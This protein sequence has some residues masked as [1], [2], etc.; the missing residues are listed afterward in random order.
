MK[1]SSLVTVYSKRNCVQCNATIRFLKK[2]DVEFSVVSL[3]DHPDV[4]EGLKAHYGVSQAPVVR[5]G[6]EVWSGFRPDKLQDL[7]A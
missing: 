2:R 6:T 1:G 3:D 7:A 5:D 4:L